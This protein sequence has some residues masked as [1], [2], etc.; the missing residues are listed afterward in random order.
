MV[1]SCAIPIEPE[2]GE[3]VE[4]RVDGGLGGALPVG[5]LDPQQQFSVPPASI[6]PIEQRGARSPDMQKA[7][8]RGS[9]TC[10]DGLAHS[11]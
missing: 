3:P 5:I 10:D 9:K 11:A 4:D 2:P 6:E 1:D 8:G 7:C